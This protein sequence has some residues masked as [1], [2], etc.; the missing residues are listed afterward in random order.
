MKKILFMM[1]LSVL[2][3][4]Q[5]FG[6]QIDNDKINKTVSCV[7]SSIYNQICELE[8]KHPE[9]QGFRQKIVKVKD[10][11]KQSIL[12]NNN[13]MPASKRY[14]S[15]EPEEGKGIYLNV[16]FK[17]MDFNKSDKAN[18]HGDKQQRASM[19]FEAA[20]K[21]IGKFPFSGYFSESYP[22]LKLFV[23]IDLTV[24]NEELGR[25]ILKIIRKDLEPL[26]EL[27]KGF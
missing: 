3:N 16:E 12:F 13:L 22:N 19:S 6:Q 23:T 18:M 4:S 9:L 7:I 11:D 2:M 25:S 26:K 20:E 10:P 1:L 24:K 15:G 21:N 17:N 5:S 8:T 27:N 14:P